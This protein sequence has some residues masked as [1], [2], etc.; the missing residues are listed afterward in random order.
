VRFGGSRSSSDQVARSFHKVR[1]LLT[2]DRMSLHGTFRVP[3][4]VTAAFRG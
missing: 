3:H 2:K 1:S 4:A